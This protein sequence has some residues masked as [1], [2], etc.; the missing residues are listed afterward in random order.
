MVD[1]VARAKW[2]SWNE[3]KNMS[4][5]RQTL[6]LKLPILIIILQSEADKAYVN[7]VNQLLKAEN[8][9]IIQ[10]KSESNQTDSKF[11]EIQTSIIFTNIYMIRLNRPTKFNAFNQNMYLEVVAA[12]K[13]ADQ[14]P[15]VLLLCMTGNGEYFSSGI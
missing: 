12:L 9:E 13:E 6:K 2:N 4:Q 5:V 10:V 11:K 15:N 1:Y 3:L 14:D 8:L 7:C